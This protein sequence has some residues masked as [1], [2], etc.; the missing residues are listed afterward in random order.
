MLACDG[1]YQVICE[2]LVCE[3]GPYQAYGMMT[4]SGPI[5]DISTDRTV[6]EDLAALCNHADLDP[7]RAKGLLEYVL[8]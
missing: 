2:T 1:K 5:H 7:R 6:V 4:R 8:P 3:E